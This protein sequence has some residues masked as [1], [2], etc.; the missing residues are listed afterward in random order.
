MH[1]NEH[2]KNLN[3]CLASSGKYYSTY[4]IYHHNT[5]KRNTTTDKK[6]IRMKRL[7]AYIQHNLIYETSCYT[8]CDVKVNRCSSSLYQKTTNNP[9]RSFT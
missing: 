3:D 7:H 2:N 9:Q 1:I 6:L 5:I 8:I 4:A